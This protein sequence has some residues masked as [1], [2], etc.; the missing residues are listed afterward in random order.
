MDMR[1][2]IGR[3]FSIIRR[4]RGLTQQQIEERSGFSQQYLSGLEQGKR[5]PSV[6]SLFEIAQALDV[7][8]LD[9]LNGAPGGKSSVATVD[10]VDA[11]Q[12]STRYVEV[13]PETQLN[14]VEVGTAVSNRI[15][16]TQDAGGGL[17]RLFA[18]ND[19]QWEAMRLRLRLRHRRSIPVAGERDENCR[20]FIDALFWIIRTGRPWR[21]LPR[22]FGKW[23]SVYRR[24]RDWVRA[25]VFEEI[26]GDTL[27]DSVFPARMSGDL[28]VWVDGPWAGRPILGR[29]RE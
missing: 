11:E 24:Y 22:E 12:T 3:N 7:G 25:G 20:L 1:L 23:N 17:D 29:I 26:L 5:N 27:S 28:I 18:L 4:A 6:I 9:L 13:W 16:Q 21:S 15:H 8:I 19:D 10:V 2:L 14:S